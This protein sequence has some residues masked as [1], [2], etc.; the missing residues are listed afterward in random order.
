VGS[1]ITPS[2]LSESSSETEGVA[3]VVASEALKVPP[4]GSTFDV[5]GP[6]SRCEK[7]RKAET[8]ASSSEIRK[9]KTEKVEKME[10]HLETLETNYALMLSDQ[11]EWKKAFYNLQ[12]WAS[13]RLG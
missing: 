8:D 10:K 5:G 6:L 1:P 7:K 4:H 3:P 2:P 12:A 9:E 11:D 13:K